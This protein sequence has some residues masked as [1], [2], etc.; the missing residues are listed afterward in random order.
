MANIGLDDLAVLLL[1]NFIEAET[2]Y[3]SEAGMYQLGTSELARARH[4]VME[5]AANAFHSHMHGLVTL[6]GI[7]GPEHERVVIKIPEESFVSWSWAF[8][9][10][11]PIQFSKTVA[12]KYEAV[13]S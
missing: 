9:C 4:A 12:R 13:Q 11:R 6:D 2:D 10:Y 1:E 7:Y 3:V 5:Q 8:M